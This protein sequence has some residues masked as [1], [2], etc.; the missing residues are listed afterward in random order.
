MQPRYK[1]LIT[2]VLCAALAVGTCFAT[3]NT[4]FLDRGLTLAALTFTNYVFLAACVA[5]YVGYQRLAG[6]NQKTLEKI[7]QIN[8]FTI[9]VPGPDGDKIEEALK[10]EENQLRQVIKDKLSKEA[11][12]M[13]QNLHQEIDKK[14]KLVVVPMQAQV[15]EKEKIMET[16]ITQAQD[17]LRRKYLKGVHEG[18]MNAYLEIYDTIVSL[19]EGY[20][21]APDDICKMNDEQAQEIVVFLAR[22]CSGRREP[23]DIRQLPAKLDNLLEELGMDHH[24]YTQTWIHRNL[25][26]AAA[27]KT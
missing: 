2:I 9:R 27:I 12:E 26:R 5:Y 14:I 21:I 22:I 17:Q 11:D 7:R 13:R 6:N 4:L 15:Q 8:A 24:T 3:I 25:S 19:M 1:F 20:G 23:N 18:E 10:A 16:A